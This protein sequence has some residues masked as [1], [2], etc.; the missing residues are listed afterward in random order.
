MATSPSRWAL[1]HVVRFVGFRQ[2]CKPCD[3]L[4]NLTEIVCRQ[5]AGKRVSRVSLVRT[6]VINKGSPA[7]SYDLAG[8]HV[9]ELVKVND[10]N[11]TAKRRQ[12]PKL[13]GWYIT[14]KLTGPTAQK[15]S[16]SIRINVR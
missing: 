8:H 6:V 4:S 14:T 9:L 1:E 10:L 11:K 7:Q 12:A 13:P 16:N 3:L 2:Q 15:Q 5:H